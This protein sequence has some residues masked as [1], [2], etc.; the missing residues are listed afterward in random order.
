M[1]RVRNGTIYA[2]VDAEVEIDV[3]DILSDIETSVLAEEL[4]R[5][6]DKPAKGANGPDGGEELRISLGSWD[7]DSLR[8]AV[9]QED[10]RRALDLLK[11][12]M[13]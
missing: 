1:A 13:Q 6:Q 8:E 2:T 3:D 9:R 4:K 10:A 12:A 11:V 7:A 5:R